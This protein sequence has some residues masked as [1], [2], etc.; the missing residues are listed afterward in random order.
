MG[1]GDGKT[2]ALLTAAYP[3]E[4]ITVGNLARLFER[5]DKAAPLARLS[6]RAPPRE[7]RPARAGPRPPRRDGISSAYSHAG[8]ATGAWTWERQDQNSSLT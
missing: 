6:R 4:Q 7:A 5:A 2:L 1:K 8:Q 3:R